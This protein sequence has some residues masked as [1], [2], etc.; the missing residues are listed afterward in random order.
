MTIFYFC[1]LFFCSKS[2]SLCFKVLRFIALWI[3]CYCAGREPPWAEVNCG[4]EHHKQQPV[5][6]MMMM[7]M[8]LLMMFMMVMMVM[9]I[10]IFVG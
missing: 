3:S 10:M 2:I 7:M 8:L 4:D 5:L 9:M 1:T 6:L